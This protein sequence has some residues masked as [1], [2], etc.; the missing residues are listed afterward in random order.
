VFFHACTCSV[1][2]FGLDEFEAAKQSFERSKASNLRP[3]LDRTTS[4]WL[5]KCEAEL[6]D[7]E[8]REEED[9]AAGA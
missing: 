4:T 9:E 2:C 1:A 3:D 7:E 5:R 6:D 8:E